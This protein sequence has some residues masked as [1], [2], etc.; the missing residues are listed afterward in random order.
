MNKKQIEYWNAYC[1]HSTY[2]ACNGKEF[3]DEVIDENENEIL[4]KSYPGQG[5]KGEAVWLRKCLIGHLYEVV[6]KPQKYKR[7]IKQFSI[8]DFNA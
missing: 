2:G 1:I 6:L 8:F 5:M 3:Y 4:C 7:N